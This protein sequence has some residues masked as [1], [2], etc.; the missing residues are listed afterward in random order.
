MCKVF[1]KGRGIFFR[2]ICFIRLKV[3]MQKEQ[4]ILFPSWL[5]DA[6]SYLLFSGKELWQTEKKEI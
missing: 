1:F 4:S 6:G 2:I 3:T 5:G